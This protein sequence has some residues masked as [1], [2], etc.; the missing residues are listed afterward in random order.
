[1]TEPIPLYPPPFIIWQLT[2]EGDGSMRIEAINRSGWA[3][4]ELWCSITDARELA[5]AIQRVIPPK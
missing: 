5:D 1:M 3:E 2:D 4:Q